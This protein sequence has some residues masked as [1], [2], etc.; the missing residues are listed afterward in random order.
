MIQLLA[1]TGTA[2]PAEGA[3]R[4]GSH[5]EQAPASAHKAMTQIYDRRTGYQTRECSKESDDG[6]IFV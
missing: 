6:E 1:R 2:A 4:G 5:R 3:E